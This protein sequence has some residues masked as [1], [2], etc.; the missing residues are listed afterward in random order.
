MSEHV[1]AVA[2]LTFELIAG[3][4]SNLTYRV[5]DANGT[6]FALRRPPTITCSRRPTTWCANTP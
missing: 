2:P 1:K 3:G 4:R 6:A 5:V